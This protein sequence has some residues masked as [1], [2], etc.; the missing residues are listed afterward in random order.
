M[1]QSDGGFRGLDFLRMCEEARKL[2][3]TYVTW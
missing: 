2:S 1:E 3:M